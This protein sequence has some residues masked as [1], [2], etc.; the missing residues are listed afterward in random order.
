MNDTP[1]DITKRAGE[2]ILAAMDRLDSNY[3]RSGEA[4]I[5]RSAEIEDNVVLKEPMIIGPNCLVAAGAYLRGGVF[6]EKDCI[7]GPNS[8]LKTTFMFSGSK[9]AHLNFVGDSIIGSGS[10]IEAGAIIANYRNEMEDKAIRIRYRDSILETGVEKFGALLGDGCRIG[11]NAVIAPGALLDPGHITRR[12]E[13]V[14]QYPL[15]A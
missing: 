8:E 11:A 10:N 15:S 1:W 7:V 4:A 2:H 9:V 3:V 12:L 6:L 5:H 14:D 13:L